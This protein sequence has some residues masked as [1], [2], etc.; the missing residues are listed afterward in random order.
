MTFR[1]FFAVILLFW[2]AIG[3]SAEVLNTGDGWL[4]ISGTTEPGLKADKLEIV[5]IATN[6]FGDGCLLNS[7]S[8][9]QN[10]Y[11][12]EVKQHNP[13]ASGQNFS[14]KARLDDVQGGF[15]DYKFLMARLYISSATASTFIVLADNL[16]YDM[17]SAGIVDVNKFRAFTCGSNTLIGKFGCAS[18]VG[19]GS[20][21][22]PY[23]DF[24]GDGME[25]TGVAVG[26]S[27]ESFAVEGLEKISIVKRFS[28]SGVLY[29]GNL[30]LSAYDFRVMDSIYFFFG[31]NDIVNGED[32]TPDPIEVACIGKDASFERQQWR[33]VVIRDPARQ[34]KTL[35]IYKASGE[36]WDDF[37]EFKVNTRYVYNVRGKF[38]EYVADQTLLQIKGLTYDREQQTYQG[39][40]GFELLGSSVR[41]K[42]AVCRAPEGKLNVI[43]YPNRD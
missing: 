4:K 24:D 18:I 39:Y 28:R 34:E 20:L 2:S 16:S 5:Y 15:C 26:K 12:T 35:K 21:G 38:I 41:I 40:V 43:M 14:F 9:D 11:V 3:Q 33:F 6:F 30:V 8:D 23:L 1:L 36:N 7:P 42:D 29:D 31:P 13:V 17:E 27:S 32:P 37:T 22:R 25:L 10:Y 19:D